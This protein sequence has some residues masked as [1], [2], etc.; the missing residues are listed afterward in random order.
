M[1]NE[2]NQW[3][4]TVEL[5]TWMGGF[6]ERLVRLVK[7]SLRKAIGKICLTNEQPLTLLKEA[8]AVVNSRPLVYVENDI[9]PY[10]TLPPSH[11]L[12][13]NPKIGLPA[14]NGD[15]IE[16][17][18]NPNITSAEKLLVTWKKGLKHLDSFW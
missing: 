6:S 13:L 2:N 7:R 1:A 12:S 3:K 17:D 16:S 14:H 5:A 9:N 18:Y 4:F 15:I 11:F 10:V 8:E